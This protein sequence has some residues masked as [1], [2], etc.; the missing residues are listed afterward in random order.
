MAEKTKINFK[1]L[2]HLKNGRTAD[3]KVG[4]KVLATGDHPNN[5]AWITVEMIK[6]ADCTT[7]IT[8][9]YF[10][11]YEI[12]YLEFDERYDEELHGYDW[13]YYLVRTEKYYNIKNEIE[14]EQLLSKWLN[15]VN[16]LKPVSNIEL[17]N[18]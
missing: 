17:P 4:A 14:L 15:D 1:I 16:D 7:Q 13:D 2:N 3:G 6:G 10:L 12:E 11:S 18:L 5:K 9:Y 8:T